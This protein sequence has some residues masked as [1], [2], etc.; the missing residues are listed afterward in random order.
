MRG[1][2]LERGRIGRFSKELTVEG[3]HVTFQTD[4][5]CYLRNIFKKLLFFLLNTEFCIPTCFC[6]FGYWVLCVFILGFKIYIMYVI[7]VL[8]WG[9]V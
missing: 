1:G 6:Q 5:S 8:V 4:T 3:I 9:S 2:H 7:L